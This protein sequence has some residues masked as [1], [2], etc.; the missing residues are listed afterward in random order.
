MG[1]EYAYF[2]GPAVS[3]LGGSLATRS[4]MPW[5][6]R[7][8]KPGFTPPDWVFGPVWSG[9]YAMMALS[10]RRISKAPRS[11][12]RQVALRLWWTQ[13]AFNAAWT[14]LFFGARRKRAA[15]ADLALLLPAVGGYMLAAR[16]VDRT[17][18]WMMAPYLLWSTFAFALN[19]ELLRLNR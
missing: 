7:Q 17:A 9:L 18:S 12:P 13:L 14:P 15:L 8:K 6:Q 5:Y 11:R 2:V 1:M 3:A 19:E 16:K 4:G 10:A